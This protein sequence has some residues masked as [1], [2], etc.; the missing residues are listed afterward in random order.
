MMV[1]G[2]MNENSGTGVAFTRNPATGEA[3]FYGEYLDQVCAKTKM[4]FLWACL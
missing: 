3:V 2:N 1:Y 4:M